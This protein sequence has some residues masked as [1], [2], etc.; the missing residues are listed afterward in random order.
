[1]AQSLPP[2]PPFEPG[3]EDPYI[4]MTTMRFVVRQYVA[5]YQ[6]PEQNVQLRTWRAEDHARFVVELV[7]QVACITSEGVLEVDVPA[8]WWQ[9]LKRSLYLHPSLFVP[10][11]A[12]A[13]WPVKYDTLVY[14]ACA[15]FP[16]LPI[17]AG[18]PEFEVGFFNWEGDWK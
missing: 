5:R 14:K 8:S 16:N 6:I 3:P 17:P 12:V 1:M 4:D 2:L 9:H 11:W 13:R 18:R 7:R 10:D 15:V